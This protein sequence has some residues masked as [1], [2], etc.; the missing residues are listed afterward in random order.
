MRVSP[1]NFI[2]YC[3][4]F[5]IPSRASSSKQRQ[6]CSGNGLCKFT[7]LRAELRKAAGFRTER[8]ATMMPAG[9][10]APPEIIDV[11]RGPLEILAE[12]L[13]RGSPAEQS[14]CARRIAGEC[15]SF[16]SFPFFFFFSFCSFLPD[17]AVLPSYITLRTTPAEPSSPPRHHRPFVSAS[18]NNTRASYI[19]LLTSDTRVVRVEHGV[20]RRRRSNE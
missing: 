4:T 18:Y 11:R 5:V 9:R 1:C 15:V 2:F 7:V 3:N 19:S 6:N 13:R 17:R 16:W 12:G 14:A 10:K 20:E 8:N